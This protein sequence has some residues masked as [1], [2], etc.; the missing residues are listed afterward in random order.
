MIPVVRH[1]TI[2]G[3]SRNGCLDVR[4]EGNQ[5]EFQLAGYVQPELEAASGCSGRVSADNFLINVG[6][7]RLNECLDRPRRLTAV[8]HVQH[9]HW[10]TI[11][12]QLGWTAAIAVIIP[13]VAAVKTDQFSGATP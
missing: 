8:T 10:E 5:V 2:Y 1:E 3:V 11:R 12:A 13:V 6:D 7:R 4:S 9:T